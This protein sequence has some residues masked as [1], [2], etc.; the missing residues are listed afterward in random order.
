MTSRNIKYQF[1]DTNA[2]VGYRTDLG[3]NLNLNPALK[4]HVDF[5]DTIISGILDAIDAE[6][7]TETVPCG[8]SSSIS[9]RK[10]TF[11]RRNGRSFSVYVPNREKILS[12]A[13]TIVALFNSTNSKIIC[14]DLKGE[15]SANL[16]DLLAVDKPALTAVA[17][18][19]P[20]V[21]EGY[22]SVYSDSMLNYNSDV[23]FGTPKIQAF[24][25]Q[26]DIEDEPY[27]ELSTEIA[28]C[29][30]DTTEVACG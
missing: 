12:A 30:G 8:E 27:S 11:T 22:K 10:L 2:F 16:L 28:D 6:A 23:V 24:Q 1:K 15:D 13:E 14:V 25:S 20:S 26:S 29:I 19:Q 17:P 18:I 4:T 5:T 21:I 9:P 7:R 3:A